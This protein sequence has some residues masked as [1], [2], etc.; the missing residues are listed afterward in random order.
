MDCFGCCPKE[1]QAEAEKVATNEAQN[2][3]FNATRAA[4]DMHNTM[5]AGGGSS[6]LSQALNAVGGMQGIMGMV[7]SFASG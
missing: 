4:P 6:A 1:L 5:G 3:V 7:Q 2:A